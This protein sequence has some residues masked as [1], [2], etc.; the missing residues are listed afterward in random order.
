M[1]D[2]AELIDTE[3]YF[4]DEKIN[5]LIIKTKEYNTGHYSILK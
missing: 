3:D 5:K 4:F 1:L 2:N